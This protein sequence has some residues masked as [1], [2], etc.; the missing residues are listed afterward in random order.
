MSLENE[1][2]YNGR[3]EANAMHCPEFGARAEVYVVKFGGSS[4]GSAKAIVEAVDFLSYHKKEGRQFVA[5]VSAFSGVTDSLEK[6]YENLCKN[7]MIAVEEQFNAITKRH[8]DVIIDLQ[9]SGVANQR[10]Q[11]E[12]A[13]VREAL[14]REI[15]GK[16]PNS[17][18][19]HDAVL[20]YG[21]RMSARIFQ[22]AL[23]KYGII[24]KAVD[25]ENVI[26]TDEVFGE[27]NPD[28]SAS[29]QK[30]QQNVIPLLQNNIIPIITGFFGADRFG[31]IHLLGRNASDYT[32]TFVGVNLPNCKGVWLCKGVDGI[33]DKDPKDPDA[34][35]YIEMTQ[36]EGMVK[37]ESGDKVLFKKTLIPV[38][39]LDLEVVVR[40]SAK[41]DHQGTRILPFSEK[42]YG[43]Q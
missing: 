33:Y 23:Q 36:E 20:S 41:P 27:A 21:E 42:H 6:L 9:L 2:C 4:L 7:D 31:R 28:I 25:A 12:M 40:P 39:G 34:K 13:S 32:A 1:N 35:L 17:C 26:V 10:L 29:L 37:A 3:P 14:R 5:V 19:V 24:G 11:T 43:V 8:N 22:S 15:E 18:E 30:I 16:E 38:Y